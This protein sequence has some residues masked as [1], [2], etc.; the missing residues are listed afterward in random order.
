[1]RCKRTLSGLAGIAIAAFCLPLFAAVESP[2][3]DA[4]MHGDIET[5]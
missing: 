3:A 2:V 4:A 1:M 5:I